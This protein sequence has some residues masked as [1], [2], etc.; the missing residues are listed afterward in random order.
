LLVRFSAFEF[1]AENEEKAGLQRTVPRHL[2]ALFT[3]SSEA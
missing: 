2:T 1:I 3:V